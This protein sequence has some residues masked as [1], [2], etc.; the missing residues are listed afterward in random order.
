MRRRPASRASP[1]RRLTWSS[2]LVE[3]STRGEDEIVVRAASAGAA[4]QALRLVAQDAGDRPPRRPARCTMARKVAAVGV[5]DAG[6]RLWLVGSASSLPVEDTATLAA[7]GGRGAGGGA[8]AP[9]ASS[10]RSCGRRRWP[11]AKCDSLPRVM[12]LAERGGHWRQRLQ[13]AWQADEPSI[14]R[15]ILMRL[16]DPVSQ[17]AEGIGAGEDAWHS[18]RLPCANAGGIGAGGDAGR[19]A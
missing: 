6:R 12:I 17:P 18:R 14:L 5:V 15:Y 19:R 7:G 9:C 3:D 4:R 1:D 10:A 13:A 8:A 11:A 16:E 2:S